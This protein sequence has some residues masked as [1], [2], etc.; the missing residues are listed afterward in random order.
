MTGNDKT[1][2]NIKE[3]SGP[4]TLRDGSA[5]ITLAMD[6]GRTAGDDEAAVAPVA[7]VDALV[8][9]AKVRTGPLRVGLE[10]AV[11]V[12]DALVQVEPAALEVPLDVSAAGRQRL[13]GYFDRVGVARV[14]EV[15]GRGR[16]GDG[17]ARG[18][19]GEKLHDDAVLDRE[20]IW[21]SK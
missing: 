21:A 20:G 17:G 18:D 6:Q 5:G 4:G 10:R 3:C 16:E 13:A 11:A 7:A 9:V 8:A 2:T 14:E 1:P 15:L 12:P 19:E